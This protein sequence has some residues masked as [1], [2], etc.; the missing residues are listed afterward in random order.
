MGTSELAIFRFQNLVVGTKVWSLQLVPRKQTGQMNFWEKSLRL[1]PQN[2][3]YELFLG[4]VSPGDQS[5]RVN[6]SGD[7]LQGQVAETMP[8]SEIIGYS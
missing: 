8:T 1:V 3:A 2:A 7:K 6:L 4:P 5:L